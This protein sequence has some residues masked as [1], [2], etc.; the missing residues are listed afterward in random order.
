MCYQQYPQ[1]PAGSSL[2][3]ARQMRSL[4]RYRSSTAIHRY[5]ELMCVRVCVWK[6]AEVR[7]CVCGWVEGS[8]TRVCTV[9]SEIQ[10]YPVSRKFVRSP[11]VL[12]LSLVVMFLLCWRIRRWMF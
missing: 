3:G 11:C 9:L 5:L 6:K 12:L 10:S 2:T 4:T 7:V 1:H 8:E